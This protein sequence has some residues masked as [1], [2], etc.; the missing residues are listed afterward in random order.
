M[1]VLK[2]TTEIRTYSVPVFVFVTLLSVSVSVVSLLTLSQY[3]DLTKAWNR[4][5]PPWLPLWLASWLTHGA[6]VLRG[7]RW[8]NLRSRRLTEDTSGLSGTFFTKIERRCL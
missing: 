2:W 4:G 1:N 3:R 7:T 5:A 8:A 6:H